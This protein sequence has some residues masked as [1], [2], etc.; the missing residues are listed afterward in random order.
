MHDLIFPVIADRHWGFS[1]TVD[2]YLAAIEGFEAQKQR[3]DAQI[4]ELRQ[5][6]TGEPVETA[7]PAAPTTSKR[8]KMSAASRARIAEAQR[9]RWEAAKQA[10]TPVAA[11]LPKKKR[12]LSAAGK[13]A[14]VE[15]TKR[16]WAAFHAAK[17]AET[18]TVSRKGAAKKNDSKKAPVKV[19]RKAA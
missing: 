2:H 13:R 19:S 15:A 3:I 8:R 4:A 5:I 1:V 11:A 9:K 7:A 14:I 12:Q 10:S 16:R 18:P 6:L 17:K